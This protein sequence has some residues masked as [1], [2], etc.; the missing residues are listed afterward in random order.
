MRAAGAADYELRPGSPQPRTPAG[1]CRCWP[2]SAALPAH[3]SCGDCPLTASEPAK[4]AA[5][6][7]ENSLPTTIA[8]RTVETLAELPFIGDQVVCLRHDQA[9]Q[10]GWFAYCAADLL[11]IRPHQVAATRR[12]RT[13]ARHRRQDHGSEGLNQPGPVTEEM[14]L[15][16]GWGRTAG[17]RGAPA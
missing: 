17:R 6:I 11:L 2:P 7:S 8:E 9:R 16:G 13:E 12:P 10:V 15:L 3:P 1:N 14:P 4:R 5:K